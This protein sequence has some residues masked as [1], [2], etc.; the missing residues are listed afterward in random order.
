MYSPRTSHVIVS[1]QPKLTRHEKK[2]SKMKEKRKSKRNLKELEIMQRTKE[3]A[4]NPSEIR[5]EYN[6]EATGCYK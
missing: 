6:Y 4:Q 1:G 5:K 2:A 3:N